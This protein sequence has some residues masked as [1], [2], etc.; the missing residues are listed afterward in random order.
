LNTTTHDSKSSI[1]MVEEKA[2]IWL[3]RKELEKV[4]RKRYK[5]HGVFRMIG[6][7]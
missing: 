4:H 6:R 7:C 3:Y 5:E 2:Q 1:V